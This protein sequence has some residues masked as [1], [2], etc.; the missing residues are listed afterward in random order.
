M[1]NIINQDQMK[2]VNEH[3]FREWGVIDPNADKY[4]PMDG[5]PRLKSNT[6]F[7]KLTKS[8][9]NGFSSKKNMPRQETLEETLDRFEMLIDNFG[10]K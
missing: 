7:S 8:F 10:T 9:S 5:I 2:Q 3:F 1:R 4:L 6:P